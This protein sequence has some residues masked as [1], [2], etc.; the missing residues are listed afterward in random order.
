LSKFSVTITPRSYETDP[1]GHI[2]N[3]ALTAW[4][5]VLR[6]RLIESLGNAL[7]MAQ[8]WVVATLAMDFLDETFYGSDVTL[9][10]TEVI[11]GNS[12]LTIHCEMVQDHRLTVK[13]RVVLVYLDPESKQPRRIPDAMRERIESL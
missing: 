1:L 5:E 6:V 3:N 4:F 7:P 12:S 2:N 9:N 13:G 10:A 11:A 8:N